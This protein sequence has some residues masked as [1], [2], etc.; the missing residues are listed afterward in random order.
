MRIESVTVK[1]LRCIR[2]TSVNLDLYTCFV[3]A[4]G[5][6]KSTMLC[7]LNIFFRNT[8]AATDMLHL[9]IEDFHHQDITSPVEITVVFTDLGA[10][11][12]E[13]FKGY[14]RQGKLAITAVAV[15]DKVTKLANVVQYGERLAMNDFA[16]F[17]ERLGDKAKAGELRPI[18][19]EL[20]DSRYPSLP[21]WKS[22][23][24]S[25]AAL[26]E[27]EAA[28]PTECEL[29]R[30]QDQFYGATK[31]AGRLD[32]YVQWVYIPAVKDAS[33]EEGERRDSAL[34]KLLARTVRKKVDFETIVDKILADARDQ[35]EKMLDENQPILA[36]LSEALSMRLR[37]WAHPE[38]SLS[39]E[40]QQD[41][42]RA[43]KAEMPLASVIA[44]EADFKGKL[45]RF[46][47]GFQ[48]SFLLALLQELALGDDKDAPR[49][50][51][52]CEEPELY[53]HPP[54]ARHLASVFERLSENNS[55]ILVTTHS[56]YF[57]SGRNFES[58]RLVHR[59]P[60]AKCSGVEEFE[61]AKIAS[62]YSAV[63][64]DPL[65]EASAALIKVHQA[66]QPTLNEM[67]F[68][69]RLILVEGLED[70]AY[71][72]TWMILTDRWEAFRRTGCHIVP[73]SGKS[74]MIRPSIIA[75]GLN[76]PHVIIFDGDRDQQGKRHEAKHI[77]DNIALLNLSGGDISVAFPSQIVWGK[78]FVCWPENI[79]T[80]VEAELMESLGSDLLE[81]IKNEVRSEFDFTADLNKATLYI[82]SLLTIA[83]QKGAKCP[84]LDR[85]CD[86]IIDFGLTQSSAVDPS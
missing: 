39:L 20:K 8:E 36:E 60:E 24:S 84:L 6:G 12:E 41:S 59:L 64:G 37:E 30:S 14:V 52:A 76:I 61:Y 4:N 44:G 16:F 56:P 31:G 9:S 73:C 79:G 32:K 7:A 66:L 28:R 54:Q 51:L 67:F 26:Q 48:R 50:I 11:A 74:E 15:Y 2:K 33:D 80:A 10:E 3:G 69:Q 81:L 85:V 53:Q 55:Q 38:A 5:A 71:L 40:W 63:T 19:E 68:T 42:N 65:K 70:V 83:R 86:W 46:G 35:Y 27:Y 22:I 34:G 17:F 43:V 18:Y 29:I 21:A 82:G 23:E 58:V 13:D 57:V 62:R 1:H 72:Q 49:L 47:H 25:A 77:R 78:R 75:S 45:A